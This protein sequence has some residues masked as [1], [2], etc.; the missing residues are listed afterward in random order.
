MTDQLKTTITPLQAAYNA[1]QATDS[2]YVH[3]SPA[4][5]DALRDRIAHLEYELGIADVAIDNLNTVI[6]HMENEG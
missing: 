2:K 6:S 1:L 5:R 4:M 3:L